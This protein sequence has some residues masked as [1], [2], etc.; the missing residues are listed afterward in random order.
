METPVNVTPSRLLWRHD[1]EPMDEYSSVT[2]YVICEN[3]LS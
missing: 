3:T 2:H 1:N